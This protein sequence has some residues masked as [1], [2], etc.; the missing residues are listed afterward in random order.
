[1]SAARQ[2]RYRIGIDVGGTFTDLVLADDQGGAI[3][4]HKLL[5][6]PHAP[7]LAPLKGLDEIF[8]MAGARGHAVTFLGLGTTVMTNALLE[9][10]G[11]RTGLI[12]TAGFRDL[13]E[14]ARQTRPHT[15]D[16]FVSKPPPLVPRELRLEVS[17]RTAADGAVLTT[18]DEDDLQAAIADLRQA[19]VESIAVCLL[20]AYANPAHELA[21]AERLRCEWP[22]VHVCVSSAVL[23]EF[24]EYERLSS[25]VVNAYLMPTTRD[26][27]NRFEAEVAGLAVPDPPFVMS[28][29]GGIMSPQQ[30]GERPI[31]TL[32]SGPSG[33]VSGAIHVA[34]RAGY[35]DIITFDMG[36]TSTDVC[37]VQAGKARISHSRVINGCPIKAAALDVHTVGA[38]GS[39][40]AALD[41]GG[42]LRV[43]P[44]SAGA[45][46]G[47][48]CYASGGE[49]PTVTDANVVLGRLNPEFLLGGA[50]R[51]D[52]GRSFAVIERMIA[53]PRNISVTEA[54]AAIVEIADTNM[55][56]AVRFVS[57]ERGLDPGDFWLVAFG[58]AG[59]VHAAAVARTLG[60]AGVLIP[61]APGVLCAMGVLVND[62][63][64]DVSRTRITREDSAD[65]LAVA[66]DVFRELEAGARAPLARDARGGVSFARS[67]DAR[68]VGQNHELT[69]GVPVG[70]FD[71]SALAML[72]ENF[73]AAHR[74]M[75][76][77]ASLGKPLEIVTYRV[78]AT[79]AGDRRDF[80]GSDSPERGGA[81]APRAS[82]KAY[83]ESAGGFVDC[84]VYAREDFRPGDRL[85]GPAIVEQMDC[86]SVIPPEFGARVDDALNLL[87]EMH[88]SRP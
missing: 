17:E 12:T 44:H 23:P 9:R 46:P 15:F 63:Q 71:A 8:A 85:H 62:V 61:P 10:K 35:R 58:G 39:S 11:A 22:E 21:I 34:A 3:V 38:G 74:E 51:I 25:T 56:Y 32:F 2:T 83:F 69:V 64:T 5:S 40:I 30:A 59:P 29:G 7:H 75:Y 42:M 18:L 86:T 26:Y 13:L 4:R 48:A 57:V 80:T 81:L 37:L 78:R 49:V 55:A 27:L 53:R 60:V 73:H 50:L 19:R 20:N 36:G 67:A 87:L 24:R 79:I 31:D 41:A 88:A 68:Y 76:G 52:A 77:Y 65:C 66:D 84:P 72:K 14:I 33:G 6:T 16:P 45:R 82:R 43:G 70:G 47:P 54:A 1:V 28:S